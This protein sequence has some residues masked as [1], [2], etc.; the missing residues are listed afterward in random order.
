VKKSFEKRG[1]ELKAE[2][3]TSLGHCCLGGEG[4][5]LGGEGEQES[6]E[7]L[8]E[9]P[10]NEKMLGKKLGTETSNHM[11]S[12]WK[13]SLTSL[14]EGRQRKSWRHSGP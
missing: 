1:A 13:L 4:R 10:A 7:P 3:E 9:R 11:K 12:G 6:S 2:V 8:C 14:L 5:F